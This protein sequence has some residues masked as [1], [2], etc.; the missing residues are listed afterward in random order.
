MPESLLYLNQLSNSPPVYVSILEVNNTYKFFLSLS[1][2]ML[3]YTL[4]VIFYFSFELAT[5]NSSNPSNSN[6]NY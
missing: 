1:L 5:I 2:K 4:L 3:E 6:T